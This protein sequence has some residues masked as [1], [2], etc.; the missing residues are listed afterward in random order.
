MSNNPKKAYDDPDFLNGHDARPIRVLCELMQPDSRLRQ[1]G[2]ENTIV[3]F[4]SARPKPSST[5]QKNLTDFEKLPSARIRK[6]C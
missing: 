3:F 4:G 5:A 1:Q 6:I 2:V